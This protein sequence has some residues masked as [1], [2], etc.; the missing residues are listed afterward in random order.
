MRRPAAIAVAVL[1]VGVALS[2]VIRVAAEL[3]PIVVL[4]VTETVPHVAPSGNWS[5]YVLTG[6]FS[7]VH[8]TF[9]VPA[10]GKYGGLAEW[11]GV[12]GFNNSDL[13][14]AGISQSFGT[15]YAW[16]EILPGFSVP[17]LWMKVSP[18]DEITVGVRRYESK[19]V[20]DI[21]D[22][23]T[24]Q[25]F[26]QQFKYGGP[27]DSA[28]WVVEAPT[29]LGSQDPVTPYSAVQ[30]SG[31]TYTG[32]AVDYHDVW[33]IQNGAVQSLPN[34]ASSTRELIANGFTV[35]YAG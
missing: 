31:L 2:P 7:E 16:W 1:L 32:D 28:E 8:G 19:W 18:G 20:V 17:I 9:T 5:G 12:D 4:P 3:A 35:E 13:I 25:F 22:R 24:L 15:N 29:S 26:F 34:T 27:A 21:L 23:S 10:V 30:F 6:K 14:Q 11:V 33:M